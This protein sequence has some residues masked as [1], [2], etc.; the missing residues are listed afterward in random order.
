MI[1]LKPSDLIVDARDQV[2]KMSYMGLRIKI[3]MDLDCLF[4]LNT[5]LLASFINKNC[6]NYKLLI[7]WWKIIYV[8]I[9]TQRS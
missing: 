8:V 5:S 6:D 4:V 7:V 3:S 9:Y 2:Y 1:L